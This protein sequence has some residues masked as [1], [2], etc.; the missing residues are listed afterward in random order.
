VRLNETEQYRPLIEGALQLR[1]A[2]ARDR[3]EEA[4]LAH[5]ERVPQEDDRAF[6]VAELT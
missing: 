2:E 3:L 1:P 5:T 6:L 4:L